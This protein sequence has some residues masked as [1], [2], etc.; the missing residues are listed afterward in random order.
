VERE[1]TTI[2]AEGGLVQ[3]CARVGGEG[4]GEGF[5]PLPYYCNDSCSLEECRCY[6]KF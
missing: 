3:C 5:V 2:G 4:E 1:A 6:N